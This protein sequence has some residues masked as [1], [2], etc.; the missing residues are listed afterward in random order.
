MRHYPD[1]RLCD[2]GRREPNYPR[3]LRPARRE[4]LSSLRSSKLSAS[5][6][7][8]LPQY[9]SETNGAP[10]GTENTSGKRQTESSDQKAL[11]FGGE[12]YTIRLIKR[13]SDCGLG[14]RSLRGAG[15]L[16]SWTPRGLLLGCTITNAKAIKP[17]VT[18]GASKKWK[19]G[20]GDRKSVV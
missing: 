14:H 4:R 16:W 17:V 2:A 18:V 10:T 9:L 5:S 6:T 11:L 20:R 19:I 3:G 15:A 8:D 12:M 7:R 1:R 13:A